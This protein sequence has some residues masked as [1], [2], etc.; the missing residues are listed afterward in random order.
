MKNKWVV[1]RVTTIPFHVALVSGLA[2]RGVLFAMEACIWF[3]GIELI[4][5][6]IVPR[7]EFLSIIRNGTIY[8][9][10]YCVVN[11]LKNLM[12]PKTVFTSTSCGKSRIRN[13]QVKVPENK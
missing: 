11:A 3:R 5:A 1:V 7:G 13:F 4:Y 9:V 2:F 12:T 6:T 8:P 10:C